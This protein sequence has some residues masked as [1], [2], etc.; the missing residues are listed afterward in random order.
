MEEPDLT[1]VFKKPG[2]QW[3]ESEI[4]ACWDWLYETNQY[5]LLLAF[6]FR[7]LGLSAQQEDAED[8][9]SE[10]AMGQ[11]QKIMQ[12][13]DPGRGRS[14]LSYLLFC[15]ARD[16]SRSRKAREKVSARKQQALDELARSMA[17]RGE[18]D[19]SGSADPSDLIRKALGMI[20]PRYAELLEDRH[21]RGKPVAQ[22]AAELEVPLGTVKAWLSKG[23]LE[24][25]TA[26]NK[27]GYRKQRD[28]R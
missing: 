27:L 23:R 26:L 25:K 28:G 18:E 10:L 3:S 2:S 22:I 9:L 4:Q 24:L 17:L 11:I 1:E 8:V 14:F 15:L 6:F 13:Y 19:E 12:S 21:F 16:C 20:T 5:R 7:H